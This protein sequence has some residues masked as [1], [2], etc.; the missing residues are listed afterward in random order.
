MKKTKKVAKVFRDEENS[1]RWNCSSLGGQIE[2][3]NY[4]T[5]IKRNSK[6]IDR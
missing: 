1:V 2:Q 3:D 5:N 4:L 6:G